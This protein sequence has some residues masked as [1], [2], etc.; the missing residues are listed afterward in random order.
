MTSR[1][2]QQSNN[3]AG[4]SSTYQYYND[5]GLRFSHSLDDRFDRAFSYDQV[6]RVSEAY[7]GSEARDFI[8]GT[9][10]GVP[11]GAFR[12]SCRAFNNLPQRRVLC[13][14][15]MSLPASLCDDL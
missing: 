12:Q 14:A 5:G 2:V 11:T 1:Q 9:N 15:C 8:N 3:Q 10:S 6:A 13:L 7:S 4:A